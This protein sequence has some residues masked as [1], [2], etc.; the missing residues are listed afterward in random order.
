[1]IKY[2]KHQLYQKIYYVIELL[3]GDMLL[4]PSGFYPS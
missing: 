3:W 4:S 1:M 2:F